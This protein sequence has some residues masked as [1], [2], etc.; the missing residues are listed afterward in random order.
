MLV[1]ENEGVQYI[2]ELL[3]AWKLLLAQVL[4]PLVDAKSCTKITA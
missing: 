1:K 4:L 3:W 2:K